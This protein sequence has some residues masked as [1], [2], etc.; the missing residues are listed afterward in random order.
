MGLDGIINVL[1]PP[2]MTSSDVVVYLRRLL[3]VKKV[4]HA[5][6]LDPNAAG[7]LVVCIGKSTKIA[8]Y[9]MEAE[10]IY[11]G[12]LVLGIKTDTLDADGQIIHESSSLP[13]LLSIE[14]V[15]SQYQ[16]KLMQHPPMYSARKHKGKRLYELA[17]QGKKVEVSPREIEIYENKILNYAAPNR[18]FFE[19]ACTKGTYIR[20]LA[21]DIGES[22]GCGAYLSFLIRIKNGSFAIDNSYSLQEIKEAFLTQGMDKMLMPM[23]RALSKFNAI[24]LDAQ[25]FSKA[26][27][28]NI[29]DVDS[30]TSDIKGIDRGDLLRVYC[31][32]QFLGLG[33]INDSDR[34]QMR[35]VLV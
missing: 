34:I 21:R 8:D 18:V 25:V 10:K 17:R 7:V 2:G 30:I 28:G 27:N 1:K 13:D 29:M 26:V 3:R 20:S 31:K 5:G 14:K 4:G 15:F 16:G 33:Y 19:V 32:G 11:R 6:T 9:I 23:D 12:E 22:L 24:E 35:K